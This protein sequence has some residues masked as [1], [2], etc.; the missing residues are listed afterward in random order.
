MVYVLSFYDSL[1][2]DV[3]FFVYVYCIIYY[4]FT[5]GAWLGITGAVNIVAIDWTG[6]VL[7]CS[8]LCESLGKSF[9]LMKGLERSWFYI[10]SVKI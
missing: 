4:E 9:E 3:L 5:W 2:L 7:E 10:D 6:L 1:F 8:K